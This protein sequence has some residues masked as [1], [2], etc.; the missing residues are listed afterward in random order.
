[1]GHVQGACCR[2]QIRHRSDKQGGGNDVDQDIFQGFPQLLLGS[3]QDDQG[4][5]GDEHHLEAYEQVEDIP[6]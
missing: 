6:R 5:G 3:A 4:I 2:I 1:M